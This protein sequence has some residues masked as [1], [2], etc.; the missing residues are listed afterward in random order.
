MYKSKHT[1]SHKQGRALGNTSGSPPYISQS[2]RQS[3]RVLNNTNNTNNTNA[4]YKFAVDEF[5]KHGLPKHVVN[6]YIG[7]ESNFQIDSKNPNSTVTG[8]GQI[9]T[10]TWNEFSFIYL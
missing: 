8:L 7:S 3:E 10:S 4:L 1:L 9:I 2:E 5:S 6:A